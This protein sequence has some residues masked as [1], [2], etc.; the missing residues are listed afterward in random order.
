V[1]GNRINMGS[2]PRRPS[3]TLESFSGNRDN[4][5]KSV[6]L[7]LTCSVFPRRPQPVS[8]SPSPPLVPPSLRKEIERKRKKDRSGLIVHLPE[9]DSRVRKIRVT[10]EGSGW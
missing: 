5:R 6:I 2:C 4:L 10:T 9:S 3:Q 1:E 7:G 8:S